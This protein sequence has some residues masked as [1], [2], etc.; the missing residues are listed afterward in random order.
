[1]FAFSHVH[2]HLMSNHHTASAVKTSKDEETDNHRPCPHGVYSLVGRVDMKI[3]TIQADPGKME[4]VLGPHMVQRQ[5]GLTLLDL[6][7][8]G[9]I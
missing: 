8:K 3:I 4:F 1:M 2:N 5:E 7:E 6:V 9:C